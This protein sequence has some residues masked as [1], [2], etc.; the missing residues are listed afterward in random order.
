MKL[1]ISGRV[2]DTDEV[3]EISIREQ[4]REV[5]VTT[6]DDFYR[7]RYRSKKDIEDVI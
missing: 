4:Q 7:I 6:N 1:R 2:F 5:F 3:R